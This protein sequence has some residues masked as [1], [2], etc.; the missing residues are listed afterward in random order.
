VG[1]SSALLAVA[2]LVALGIEADARGCRQTAPAVDILAARKHAGTLPRIAVLAVGANGTVAAGQLAR[3]NRILGP[4]GKLGLVTSA[5]PNASAAAM[6]SYAAAHPRTTILID[7]AASGLPQRYGGGDPVHIGPQGEAVMARYIRDH[8][9]PYV[10]PR[11]RIPFGAADATDCGI[12][13][14]RQVLVLRGQA[15]ILCP[16]ALQLVAARR[17]AAIHNWL[18][19]DWSFV[20]SPPWTDVFV[21]T[22]G[23]VIVAARR[24]AP[25]PA[26]GTDQPAPSGG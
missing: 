15:R 20:G 11:R 8:I 2:P 7:W 13:G 10:P 26:P 1:D 3:A 21:R 19:Y 18:Y 9:R 14:G 25:A 5:E 12:T 17:P 4:R 23:R 22:D 6:R 16:R 24:P